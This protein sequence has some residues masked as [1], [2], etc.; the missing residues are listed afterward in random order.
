M[1]LEINIEQQILKFL[2][3][4]KWRVKWTAEDGSDEIKHEVFNFPGPGIA[5]QCT[6]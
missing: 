5:F 4:V 1:L 3:K 2:V 6:I